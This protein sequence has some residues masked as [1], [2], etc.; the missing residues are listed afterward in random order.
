MTDEEMISAVQSLVGDKRLE[1][2]AEAYLQIAKS[3]VV[4]RL[5]PYRADAAWADVPERHH[6]RT[7]Q[8]AVYLV[9]RRGS[10]GETSHSENGVSRAYGSADIPE[11]YFAG[12]HPAV[13]VPL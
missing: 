1:G 13:G 12:M 3:A 11:G 2:Y 10:E 8:I 7:V 5:F 4:G 9:N 6:G